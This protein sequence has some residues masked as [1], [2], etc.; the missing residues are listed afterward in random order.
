MALYHNFNSIP[1][2]VYTFLVGVFGDNTK[3]E[4]TNLRHSLQLYFYVY[5]H[6]L[7]IHHDDF[8]GYVDITS[9]NLEK[10]TSST[11][12][13]VHLKKLIGKDDSLFIRDY[14]IPEIKPFG[15][16]INPFYLNNISDMVILDKHINVYQDDLTQ[17]LLPQ[18]IE[19]SKEAI[20]QLELN[21]EW[22][23]ANLSSE[24]KNQLKKV[25]KSPI[26]DLYYQRLFNDSYI[27]AYE[28]LEDETFDAYYFCSS[29]KM[30]NSLTNQH[31]KIKFTTLLNKY[32]KEK[33]LNN[34]L[35]MV[36]DEKGIPHIT[37][38]KDFL[39]QTE[40]Q[41]R[42]KYM[43]PFLRFRDKKNTRIS[44][45]NVNGRLNHLV[46]S[47]NK[48]LL[49]GVTINS[50]ALESIDLKSSQI[51]ILINLMLGSEKL[52]QSL[53][54]SSLALQDYLDTFQSVEI[55]KKTELEVFFEEVIIEGDIYTEVKERLGLKSRDNAKVE[56]LKLLYTEPG[57]KSNSKTFL[58]E[59]FPVFFE[60]LK[61]IQ[62]KFSDRYGD[63]KSTLSVF[64]Q[65]VEAHL[66]IEVAYGELINNNETR[67][68]DIIT[69]HDSFIYPSSEDNYDRIKKVV[70]S[71]FGE[72]DFRYELARE[73]VTQIT[74]KYLLIEKN[75]KDVNSFFRPIYK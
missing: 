31:L 65:M 56:M 13:K 59:K 32:L 50:K 11:F 36:I 61:A 47:F 71:C 41:N 21:K 9:K 26:T 16:T 4:I 7:N 48:K 2:N 8:T 42:T 18:Q 12:R 39:K 49:R 73:T 27:V 1:S 25:R 44:V 40:K 19:K 69:K 55:L 67:H 38:K 29:K 34:S 54:N 15:Y 20:T 51:T 64:M 28:D 53:R 66:F 17:D 60:Q 30:K 6:M 57:F 46:T 63:S 10:L 43:L 62:N 45:S 72:R 58:I 23:H 52:V 74:E 70:E 22:L 37:T 68:I 75:N 14:Y 33:E 24:F 3:R 5:Y 35:I